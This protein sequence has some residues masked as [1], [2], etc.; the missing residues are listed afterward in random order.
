MRRRDIA[1]H[2]RVQVLVA[3]VLTAATGASM[4]GAAPAAA[5]A[6][7]VAASS[8]FTAVGVLGSVAA[9]SAQNAWAVGFTGNLEGEHASLIVHWNGTAWRQMPSPESRG[10]QL[11]GVAATSAGN[12]WAVGVAGNKSLI[13]H[14]NGTM[15]KRA[16][17]PSM[18]GGADLIA[19]AATS[20]RNA[21]A[22]GCTG[23]TGTTTNNSQPLIVRWNGSAWKRVPSPTTRRGADLVALAATSARNA[24]AVG[25][26]SCTGLIGPNSQPLI[27]RWNGS[28]WKRV[29]SPTARGGAILSGVAAA[30]AS[31]AWAVGS[32]GFA[33]TPSPATLILHWNGTAWRRV[34]SPHSGG[35]LLSGVAATSAGN[36]W[37]VGY[38]IDDKPVLLHWNGGTWKQ[39]PSPTFAVGDDLIGVAAISS[40]NAWAVG[41]IGSFDAAEPKTLVL[42]WN[43]SSWK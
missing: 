23:C 9:V 2:V 13:L 14:W 36:A 7:P 12:A 21:W 6:G 24:W 3:S 35:G 1:K 34:S 42:H 5:E 38:T 32:V 41:S 43:G 19:V 16:V 29:P 40:R 33:L 17:S 8:G 37:A 20:A 30:S 27:V 28:G 4:S 31:H 11:N 18:P 15:W 39:V 10:S 25:C 22:V 26:T